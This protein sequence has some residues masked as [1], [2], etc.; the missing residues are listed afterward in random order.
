MKGKVVL[1]TGAS[2]GLGSTVTKAFLDA[3][4]FVIG[5]ARSITSAEFDHPNFKPMPADIST[6]EKTRELAVAIH[7][8]HGAID[9]MVHL[10]GAFAGGKAIHETDPV[11][12]D[13]MLDLNFR[14]SF[15]MLAAVLPGM[16]L[17]KAGA[18][19]MIGS[20]AAV[21]APASLG[22]YAASKA[23]L[24]SLV[25]TAALE[26]KECGITVNVILPG[27]MD[28]PVNRAAMPD[29]DPAK[30]VSPVDVAAL[31]LSIAGN[32][33]VSGAVI[34]IYGGDL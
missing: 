32:K 18:V 1:I 8:K 4:A 22:V 2:G 23:A 3:G 15:N 27:T 28:T 21:D 33:A 24:V 11:T 26:N 14:S 16:R 10:V 5:V 19:L 20:R 30:W 17:R 31:L 12:M 34:P 29:A 7:A 9:V 6:L 13:K 25:R